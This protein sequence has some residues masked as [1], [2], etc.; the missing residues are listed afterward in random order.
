MWALSMQ[1]FKHNKTKDWIAQA[2]RQRHVNNVGV[3]WSLPPCVSLLIALFC[4]IY[5]VHMVYLNSQLSQT[6]WIVEALFILITIIFI[7]LRI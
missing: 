7:T 1:V 3:T 6:L 4:F 5:T 2:Y